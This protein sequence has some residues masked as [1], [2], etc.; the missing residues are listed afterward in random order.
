LP[1]VFHKAKSAYLLWYGYYQI[2]PKTH[3][4]TLGKKLD[5]TFLAILE[6]ISVAAFLTPSE[7]VPYIKFAI[8]K[9]D[10]LKIFLML[11]WE[12]KSLDD[13]KYI[14]LSEKLEEIGRN[15]GGW[16]GKVISK[17]ENSPSETRGEK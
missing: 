14:E 15:L 17:K 5:E 7:K 4:Y 3:R 2:L 11:L 12:T 6:A 1:D 13:K 10:L 9:M 16:L 8:K